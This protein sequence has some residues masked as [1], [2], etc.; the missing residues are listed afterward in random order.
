[1]TLLE[2]EEQNVSAYRPASVLGSHAQALGYRACC[3]KES[4]DDDGD[5][6]DGRW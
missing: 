2:S 4:Q 6:N 1:M 3:K 5:D